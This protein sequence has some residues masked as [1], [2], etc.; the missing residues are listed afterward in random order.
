MAQTRTKFGK[1][2]L[3]MRANAKTHDAIVRNCWADDLTETVAAERFPETG[4]AIQQTFFC[5]L[6]TFTRFSHF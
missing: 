2:S 3:V 6:W 5:N 4:V 1:H